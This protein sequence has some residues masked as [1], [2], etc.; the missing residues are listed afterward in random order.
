MK[1]LPKA[2]MCLGSLLAAVLGI[3]Q[4]ICTAALVSSAAIRV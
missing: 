4:E 2:F 1:W 3:V